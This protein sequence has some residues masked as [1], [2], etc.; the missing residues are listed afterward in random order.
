MLQHSGAY[1]NFAVTLFLSHKPSSAPAL[2]LTSCYFLSGSLMIMNCFYKVEKISISAEEKGW[3]IY[4]LMSRWIPLY[5]ALSLP[6]ARTSALLFENRFFYLLNLFQLCSSPG[7]PQWKGQ[8]ATPTS[9][10]IWCHWSSMLTLPN[11]TLGVVMRNL[12]SAKHFPFFLPLFYFKGLTWR[13]K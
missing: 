8:S 1:F 10:T 12:S 9:H 11:A 5:L 6:R 4:L 2:I 7:I 3:S 13:W